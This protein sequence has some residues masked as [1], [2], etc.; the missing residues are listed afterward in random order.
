MLPK[1]VTE[2]VTAQVYL[3]SEI[4]TKFVRQTLKKL[5]NSGTGTGAGAGAS[6]SSVM[7]VLMLLYP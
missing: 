2:Y 4:I 3:S 1:D 6:R 5:Q 7:H